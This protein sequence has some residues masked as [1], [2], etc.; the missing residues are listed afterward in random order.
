MR[1]QALQGAVVPADPLTDGLHRGPEGAGC[2]FDAVLAG[3]LDEPE[4]KVSEQFFVFTFSEHGVIWDRTH[5]NDLLWVWVYPGRLFSAFRTGYTMLSMC[6]LLFPLWSE[7]FR[8]TQ[9]SADRLPQLLEGVRPM[10]A[11]L[12]EGDTMYLSDPT[13][14]AFLP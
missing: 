1:S 13:L 5:G 10:A 11:K 8:L 6:P 9:Q 12:P 14:I 4:A 3:V 7:G 2:R